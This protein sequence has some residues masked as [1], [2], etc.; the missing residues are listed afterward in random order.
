MRGNRVVLGALL[1]TA[2]LSGCGSEDSAQTGQSTPNNTPAVLPAS[3]VKPPRQAFDPPKVF[4]PTS[5]EFPSGTWGGN[6]KPRATLYD[7]NIYSANN[8]QLLALDGVTAELLWSV[9]AKVKAV[10]SGTS[11]PP[12]AYKDH[13]Y[14]AFSGFQPSQGT[15]KPH[16]QIEV[17]SVDVKTGKPDFSTTIDVDLDSTISSGD[18]DVAIAGVSDT[19]I[20]VTYFNDSASLGLTYAVDAATHNVRW[21]K[22]KFLASEVDSG[23]VVGNGGKPMISS[24][25]TLTG[26]AE[27]DGAEKWSTALGGFGTT[28]MPI[29]PKLVASSRKL[30]DS[31]DHQFDIVDV[32]TGKAVY[33]KFTDIPTTSG[34]DIECFYDQ[35]SIIACSAGVTVAFAFEADSVGPNPLW[36]IKDEGSRAVPSFTAAYHD[37]LYGTANGN[38]VAIDA[39]TGKDAPDNPGVAPA[40]L[41]KYLATASGKTYKP[42]K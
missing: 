15:T 13:M 18:G 10:T 17:V 22:D 5:A 12:V 9:P 26:V 28:L 31:L 2:V 23:M 39:K 35:R 14:V 40:Q 20:V 25:R 8:E 19:S 7:G 41:D 11:A 30:Y 36:E 1:I 21:Q 32:T 3:P 34:F 27:A 6:N 16:P 24:P 37:L 38:P 29:S 33:S 4:E 42:T